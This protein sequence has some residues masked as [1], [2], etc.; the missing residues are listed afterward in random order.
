MGWD[1]SMVPDP[2]DPTTFARSKL[3]WTEPA[4]DGHA[5]ILALYRNLLRLR[6]SRPELTD[7]RLHLTNAWY[8]D[9][10]RWLVM[11]RGDLRVAANLSDEPRR[12]PLHPPGSGCTVP[13]AE[14][15]V[16]L[17]TADGIGVTAD[18][19]DLP[20]H[21]AAVVAPW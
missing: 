3:D 9:A 8:D 2:Q 4:S 5:E 20:P 17:A 6:R 16:L 7:P 15:L 1:P 10:Q 21:A 12:V 19:I 13:P 18:G 11:A 14:P